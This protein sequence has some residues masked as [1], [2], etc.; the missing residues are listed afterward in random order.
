MSLSKGRT[1]GVGMRRPMSMDYI[2]NQVEVVFLP[3]I[4]IP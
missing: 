2:S 3:R 4:G 1:R